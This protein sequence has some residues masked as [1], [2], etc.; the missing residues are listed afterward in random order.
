V[1]LLAPAAAAAGVALGVRLAVAVPEGDAEAGARLADAASVGLPLVLEVAW[2]ATPSFALGA[3]GAFAPGAPGAALRG[4]CDAVGASGTRCATFGADAGLRAEWTFA[5]EGG[6][7]QWAALGL[8]YGWVWQ[9]AGGTQQ[10]W[11]GPEA[12][13]EAGLR[14]DAGPTFGWGPFLGATA[15][16]FATRMLSSGGGT[17][18][19]DVSE[20][21]VHAW[22]LLGL[23]G[24][25]AF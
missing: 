24:T 2:T 16:R 1:L 4:A 7:A 12:L 21:A 13:A 3:W 9:R 20:R 8:G 14:F 23:R 17:A 18:S 25:W 22:I 5:R 19:F 10:G 11:H 15:G 6:A